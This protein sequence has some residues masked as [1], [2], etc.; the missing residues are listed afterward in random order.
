[1]KVMI[2]SDGVPGHFNQSKG[3]SQLIAEEINFIEEI[4]I[5]Q[6]KFFIFRSFIKIFS[7]YLCKKLNK[8]KAKIIKSFY[9]KIDINS[10][11]LII[12]AGGN[13]AA[14]SAAISM[15]NDI[16]N[17]QLG[18]PRGIHSNFFNAHL[19][20]ERY[21]ETPNNIVVD[22]TPNLY[23]PSICKNAS[24]NLSSKNSCLLLMGGNGIAHSYTTNEWKDLLKNIKFF[25]KKHNSE[26][27]IVTSRRT[28][29]KIEELF[30]KE[31]FGFYSNKSIWFN[32]GGKN[33]NLA[34][35]LGNA[36]K[37]FVTED[38][39]MMISESISS[40]KKVT[41]LYPKN[42]HAPI[43]YKKHIQK[44]IELDLIDSQSISSQLNLELGSDNIE[45]IN[46][47]RDKLRQN[48]LNRVG[49]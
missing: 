18:S 34:K 25:L 24:D 5:L 31:L 39:T 30:R 4:K 11:D 12:A 42:I 41:T 37:V 32:L 43:R 2:L 20:I 19:T 33:A 27:V 35:L 28:D 49:L 40:G 36:C 1:M 22:V 44:Y 48:I 9:K 26:I 16:P 7:R 47:I 38:S 14:F 13:T 21:F 15:L 17:I 8:P 46:L 3:V 6:P 45:K 10:Y 23:S 29:S